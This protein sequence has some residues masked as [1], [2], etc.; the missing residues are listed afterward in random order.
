M[1][2]IKTF[3]IN[4]F[5]FIYN[6]LPYSWVSLFGVV[7]SIL[8]IYIYKQAL[9]YLICSHF[10]A[11]FLS[12]FYMLDAILL[13]P[14]LIFQ[15]VFLTLIFIENKF[16]FRIKNK[17]LRKSHLYK[18]ILIILLAPFLITFIKN[19]IILI[20]LLLNAIWEAPRFIYTLLVS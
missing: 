10:D 3:F 15:L 20:M 16:N 6:E 1:N 12:E 13:V 14:L 11:W 17:I 5:K 4:L 2:H 7:G 9:F 19:I 8:I 18:I